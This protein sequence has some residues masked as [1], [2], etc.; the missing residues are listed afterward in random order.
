MPPAVVIEIAKLR[1]KLAE[2]LSSTKKGK[3]RKGIDRDELMYLN[4]YEGCLEDI[5]IWLP[6]DP[7]K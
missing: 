6:P 7:T 1:R 3:S 4:G 2:R 5:L